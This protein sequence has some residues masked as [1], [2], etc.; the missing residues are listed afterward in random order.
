[1]RHRSKLCISSLILL[2]ALAACGGGGGSS[3]SDPAPV[4]TNDGS[5][6]VKSSTVAERPVVVIS[7]PTPTSREAVTI[8]TSFSGATSIQLTP[9]GLGCGTIP[10]Q[11]ASSASLTVTGIAADSGQCIFTADITTAGGTATFTNEFTIAPATVSGQGLAFKNGAY[12][13]SGEYSA[14]AVSGATISSIT[15]PQSLI[16]GGSGVIYLAS[17]SVTTVT[18][19]VFKISGVPGY[20]VAKPTI[21]GN[22]LRFD[23]QVGQQF[24]QGSTGA[25]STAQLSA[26][27]VDQLGGV[28]AALTAAL[29]VQRV[30]SGPLQVSL[31]FD[32]AVDVDL[33]VVTPNGSEIYYSNKSAGGGSLD[34]D[35]N[36]GCNI[37]RINNENIVWPDTSLPSVGTYKVLVDYYQACNASPV[38]YTVRVTNCGVVSTYTGSFVQSQQ[39]FGA[40]GSGR[41]VASIPY[42]SCSGYSTSGRATYEDFAPTLNGLSTTARLLPIRQAKVEVVQASDNTVLATGAT[43]DNGDFKINFNMT[44]PGAYFVR[45]LTTRVSD[46]VDQEVVNSSNSLYSVKS[47]Q[48][49]SSTTRNATGI[50]LASTRANSFAGAFNI[51]DLGLL[52]FREAKA[53]F[54]VSMPHLTWSWTT[55]QPQCGGTAS[56]FQAASNT[57]SVLSSADDPDEYDD[58]VLA[59][60]FGHFIMAQ[61]SDRV[62]APGGDHGGQKVNPLLAW[63]EGSATFLGQWIVRSPQYLDTKAT[64]MGP[65]FNIEQIASASQGTSDGTLSGDVSEFSV[66]AILWDLADSAQDSVRMGLLPLSSI[67]DIVANVDAVFDRLVALK[68]TTKNR[69]VAGADLVD[70]L[71]LWVCGGYSTWESTQGSNFRGLIEAIN[72]FPYV[73]QPDTACR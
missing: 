44:T 19:A 12:F 61:V 50:V 72:G 3:P 28:S 24:L 64:G 57:I 9:T 73:A 13:S 10:V 18:K 45:A 60:E 41:L 21:E 67:K 8:V 16:N 63:S 42:Q 30:G 38:A 65:S 69:G 11:R 59:H 71:D 37:D 31:S 15:V 34:L 66:A 4:S 56:C 54:G 25:G 29:N 22:R 2:V 20:F 47:A 7:N 35:S 52:G 43:D 53:R 51:F 46:E 55:G 40:A 62:R 48:Q 23:V 14:S 27:L 17:N 39:D 68:T 1:M 33:H 6:H 70:F 32:N 5:A 58:T 36:A 49:N 26:R